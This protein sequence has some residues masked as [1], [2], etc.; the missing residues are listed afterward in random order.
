ML[1]WWPI[2]GDLVL[3]DLL[4][5]VLPM[6]AAGWQVEDFDPSCSA[7]REERHGSRGCS[8]SHPPRLQRLA[9]LCHGVAPA[10]HPNRSFSLTAEFDLPRIT[11][12][13]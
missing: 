10:G 13:R 5:R 2:G 11:P 7:T 9:R 1:A 8:H 4:D 12:A 3:G 6:A